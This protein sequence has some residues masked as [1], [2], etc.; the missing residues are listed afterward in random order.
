METFLCAGWWR[1]SGTGEGSCG[2]ISAS[3]GT[4]VQLAAECIGL[5]LTLLRRMS[6][7]GNGRQSSRACR[8]AQVQTEAPLG[9]WRGGA[10]LGLVF[11]C[12]F[13]CF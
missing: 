11:F 3:R 7:S 9:S 6:V 13:C 12:L 4:C 5:C 2:G 1:L 8:A 10:A